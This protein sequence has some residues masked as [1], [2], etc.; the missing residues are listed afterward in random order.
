MQS[1]NFWK[2]LK[3]PVMTVA[4]MSGVTDEPFRQ[5]LLKLGRPDVFWTEFVSVDGLFSEGKEKLLPILKF[6]KSEHPIVA[7]VFGAKPELFEKAAKLIK[8]LGFDGIDINMGCP[9]RD[10]EKQGGGAALIKNFN[11]AKNII[12]AAKKGAALSSAKASAGKE[13][14]VSVKTRIGYSKDEID[15]WISVLLKEDLA[16]LTVHFRTRKELSKPPAHWDLAEKIVKLRDKISPETLIFGNGDVKSLAEA[17]KLARETGLDGIMIGR[18]I[19]ANPWL[20]SEKSPTPP[21]RLDAII[22]HAEIF[23]KLNK[24]NIDKKG[25]LKNF[26]S[27]KKFFK[28]YCSGFSGAKDLRE[29]LMSARSSA[30]I[31]K[32]IKDFLN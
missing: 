14:P 4:P 15:K 17:K 27:I 23:E 2:K 10:I 32:I 11:L 5:M 7:Q 26:S 28:S 8:K 29:K 24:H 6:A 22:K 25:E 19:L 16:A 20:F 30:E 9:N 13:M 3:R 18:G 21:Q 31:K 12:R 1:N